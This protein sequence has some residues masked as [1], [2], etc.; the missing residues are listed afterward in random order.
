MHIRVGTSGWSYPHWKKRFYPAGLPASKE[1]RFAAE[2]MDALEI[3]AT[4]YRA[5]KP[6]TFRS[7]RAEISDLPDFRLAV[8]GSRFI[9]HMKKLRGVDEALA[10]F[11]ATGPLLLGSALGP[12][13]WQLPPQL[14]Y[15]RER[16][17]GFFQ[18]LPRRARDAQRLA[19][20]STWTGER[21]T[22][23]RGPGLGALG[24][25]RYAV[26]PRHA[27]YDTRE[28]FDLC[29]EHDVAVVLAD[30]AGKHVWLEAIHPP[31]A[32]VRLHGSRKLYGSQYT[33]EELA[34]WRDRLALW[35]ERGVDE[36]YVFFDNDARGYAAEDAIRLRALA[37]GAAPV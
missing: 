14:P 31:L 28:F 37:A 18:A 20:S 24:R 13:L 25:L 33:D 5:A 23:E 4:F 3:N 35:R 36:A 12:I 15:D 1:M 9:T 16:L 19:R 26:E 8:K 30:T 7:W 27:S 22:D 10:N 32:Y 2:R 17:A 6:S 34:G 11:F 21:G 29:A